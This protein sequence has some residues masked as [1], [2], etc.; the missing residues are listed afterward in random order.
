MIK[1]HFFGKDCIIDQALISR[2]NLA[3]NL[4][5]QQFIFQNILLLNQVHGKEVVTI[6]DKNKI[7]G[8]TN[9]PKAD[10]IV[11]N[12][13]EVVLGIVTADCSP[14]LLFD[15]EKKVIGACHAGWR[16]A[17]AGV[18]SQTIKEMRNLGAKNISALIGPMIQQ[19]SYEISFEF[20]DD[21][22]DENIENKF[23]FKT[24]ENSQKMLF[25]LCGYVQNK[26]R[27]E[28]ISAIEN[29]AIDTYQDEKNYFS[30]RRSTHQNLVD[31]GRNLAVIAIN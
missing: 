2:E 22:I 20:Y 7:Y 28:G 12:L 17:K 25:D 27:A 21:F 6:N 26:L 8:D 30:F 18:I 14:I 3:L 13:K 31:S 10:G 1:T 29:L 19:K 11:C 5:N 23:F 24:I 9:L 4:K 16:G 15:N